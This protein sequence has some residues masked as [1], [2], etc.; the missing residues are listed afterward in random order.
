MDAAVAAEDLSYQEELI[1]YVF[2][3]LVKHMEA[4]QPFVMFNGG[5][6]NFDWPGSD[7]YWK[8][9]LTAQKRASF[10]NVSSATLCGLINGAD[11]ERRIQG[12]VLYDAN[13]EQEEWTLPIATTIAG[14]QQ[15]LPVTLD[16]LRKHKCLTSL[17]V[18]VDLTRQPEMQNRE[19]AW[20]WAFEHLLPGSSKKVAFNLYHYAPQIHTDAQSNATLSNVDWAVQQKAFI[21]NFKTT[22]NP[23]D[24]VNPL[25]SKALANMDPLF[26]AYGWTDEEFG[27]VWMAESSGAGPDGTKNASSSGGGG[28]V[29]CSFA[30]PNLSFW[31]L[32]ALPNG[33]KKARPLPVYDRQ[34]EL[35]KTKSYVLIET[36]EGD[37]PRIVVSAFSKAWI[38]PRRGSLPISWAI[39]PMLG[40]EF[41]ALFDY[42]SSTAGANDSFISGPGGCGY[43]YYGRMT[44]SQLKNFAGRCGRL[45]QDDGPKVIDTFGQQGHDSV[46]LLTKF[47]RYAKLG[48]AAPEMYVTQPTGNIHYSYYSCNQSALD[49]WQPD[50]TPMVCTHGG[51]FYVMGDLG[52][53]ELAN[54]IN[55]IARDAPRPYFITVYGGLK[56]TAAATKPT[57]SLYNFWGDAIAHL[58]ADIV[59][60]GAQEMARLA[61]TAQHQSGLGSG[62]DAFVI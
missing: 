40:E 20:E 26:S 61:R 33:L 51:I 38:D 35:D 32:L 49:T 31:K 27:F 3:G 48:G 7:M 28:A 52:G 22:G 57:D 25:F 29:F 53:K 50:G 30:T 44:D 24:K 8:N 19:A 10:Q 43:V 11:P 5:Y 18:G 14:Q 15:L 59:P 9:W 56:W 36:N 37:T 4:K 42:F 1:A 39:D 46:E 16:I 21:M 58:D 6:L 41:P 12:V 23:A 2:E 34:M 47:S 13:G 60:V 62:H 45:M 55:T 54:R 17:S